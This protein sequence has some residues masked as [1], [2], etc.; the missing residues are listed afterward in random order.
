MSRP[1]PNLPPSLQN[2]YHK[3]QEHAGLQALREASALLVE[4]VEK[5]A[6]MSN[7][8]ADGGEGVY[9]SSNESGR[10]TDVQQLSETFIE[11]HR[12]TREDHP[13]TGTSEARL[14]PFSPPPRREEPMRPLTHLILGPSHHCLLAQ[15]VPLGGRTVDESKAWCS[16]N[17][18]ACEGLCLGVA[19]VVLLFAAWYWNRRRT[20]RWKDELES[21]T[22]QARKQGE[23]EGVE[24][25]RIEQVNNIIKK[26]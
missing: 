9:Y 10:T 5:L 12:K 16:A 3:Q 19:I 18:T 6:Q 8:M 2:L 22:K 13:F 7:I 20:K 14:D 4:R 23:R 11:Q 25:E 1:Q 21:A 26:R 15:A 24:K 17:S